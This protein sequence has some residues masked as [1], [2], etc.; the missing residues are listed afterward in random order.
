MGENGYRYYGQ[1][2]LLRL[3]QILFH[4]ELGFRLEA[5]AR[6]LDDPGFDQAAALR[7][8]RAAL[9]AQAQR[10]RQ[11]V[12]TL[13]QT[14]AALEGKTAMNDKATFRGFPPEKQAAHEAWLT[15]RFG[16][17]VKTEIEDSKQRMHAL[18]QG[19]FD[20]LVAELEVLEIEIAGAMA[21]GLPAASAA[22][23]VLIAR[24]HAWIARSWNRAPTAEAYRNL[25]LI[26]EDNPDFRARYEGRAAGFTEYLV[27]AM[28]AYAEKALG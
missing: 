7:T 2:E 10:Y 28:R 12:R 3:Q 13:D 15:D 24:H 19:Q 8:H 25:A 26:Y 23:G 5:I 21:K 27:A 9:L 1:A 16:D 11:L 6:I 4:R 17:G 20:G 22:V 18:S 14:L